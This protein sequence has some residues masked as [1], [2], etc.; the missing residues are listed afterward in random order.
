MKTT[1][2]KG[3]TLIELIV[4]MAVFSIIMFGA[5]NL[6]T[7]VSKVMVQTENYEN[8]NA[9][10]SNISDYLENELSAAEFLDTYNTVPTNLETV[11]KDF[12]Q[13][14]YEG[15]LKSGSSVTSPTYATG[16]VHV[17]VID[18][19]PDAAGNVNTHIKSYVY[20]AGFETGAV[21]VTEESANSSALNEAY[22]DNYRFEIKLGTYDETSWLN[23]LTYATFA[24]N[25]NA[26]QT[27]FTIRS[28]TNKKING[29]EY[30]FLTNASMSLANINGRS[31]SSLNY[32]VI[33]DNPGADAA[34]TDDNVRSIKQIASTVSARN[35]SQNPLARHDGSLKNSTR[36]F[37]TDT[38]AT[39]D[40][41]CI[42]YSYGAEIQTQ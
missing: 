2:V 5:M 9:V 32:Y 13:Y 23:P 36:V 4:V 26:K 22:Y 28:T 3:F 1:S 30:S 8:G 18:N 11:A 16:K 41:Y 24:G 19:T 17:M 29:N 7:P 37:Y 25:A 34:L 33:D 6:M 10:V 27:A 14:Y 42:V 21:S 40:S 35:G 20:N 38:G 39:L 15:V 31:L 12:A